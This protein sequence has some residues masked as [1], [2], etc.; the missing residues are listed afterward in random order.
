MT[1]ALEKMLKDGGVQVLWPNP[2]G[3]EPKAGEYVKILIPWIGGAETEGGRYRSTQWHPFSAYGAAAGKKRDSLCITA[4]GDWTRALH[5][6]IERPTTRPIW[7]QGPFP[8]PYAAYAADRDNL[9]LVATG[10]GI[11]P[12]LATRSKLSRSAAYAA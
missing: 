10:I 7:V 8:A 2:P 4:A 5:D 9:L 12:A 1:D 3:F 6:A 11:A